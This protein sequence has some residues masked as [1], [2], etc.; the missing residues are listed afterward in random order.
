MLKQN[1]IFQSSMKKSHVLF[2]MVKNI[3]LVIMLL[4]EWMG[5]K[6]LP[7]TCWILKLR[8]RQE[9]LYYSFMKF[10]VIIVYFSMLSGSDRYDL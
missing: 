4:Q 9:L 3:E 10:A 6:I 7:C 1:N 8:G 5:K 2:L